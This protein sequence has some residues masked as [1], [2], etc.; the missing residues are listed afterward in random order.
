MNVHAHTDAH[1]SSAVRHKAPEK[2]IK[3]RAILEGL[4][5]FLFLEK[6]KKK[7]MIIH[8]CFRTAEPP[9]KKD[10]QNKTSDEK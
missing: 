5:F 1:F 9:E 2:K 7:L 4:S 10:Q 6:K 3:E 8:F